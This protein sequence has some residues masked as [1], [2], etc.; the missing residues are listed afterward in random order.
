ME[1]WHAYV[2]FLLRKG[3]ILKRLDNSLVVL[4]VVDCCDNRGVALPR[5]VVLV[6]VCHEPKLGERTCVAREKEMVED[7]EVA[8]SVHL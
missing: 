6:R 4:L 3:H 1:K 8:L 7:V 2:D 5:V